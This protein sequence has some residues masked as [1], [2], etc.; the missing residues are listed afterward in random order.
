MNK[1]A[2]YPVIVPTITAENPHTYREQIERV[3]GF[4]K[5]LHIDLMDG[6]FT[7]NKS[8][9]LNQV[10]WPE[11]ITA[12]VHLMFQDPEAELKK[13][14]KLK[15]NMVVVHAESDCDVPKFAS[16]LRDHGI[17]TGLAVFPETSIESIN[18]ILPHVQQLLIF[19]GNLGH[20]GGSVA[21]LALLEKAK[22]AK[23]LHRWLEEIAWD[24]GITDQNAKKLVEGGVEV[25]NSGGFIQHADNPEEAYRKLINQARQ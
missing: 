18:Y 23:K 15:P 6:I 12:D 7:K 4:A 10:W 2:T 25:L 22:E 13:L 3:E 14:I 1:K 17:K 20:Q 9:A 5:R 24:G 8:I 19:S 16:D 21:D 11:N